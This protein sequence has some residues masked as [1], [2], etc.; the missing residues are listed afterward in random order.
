MRVTRIEPPTREPGEGWH[1][2]AELE[3]AELVAIG[4]A[5]IGAIKH[6]RDALARFSLAACTK[7]PGL[8]VKLV[9]RFF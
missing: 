6:V 8:A 7:F 1:V 5:D 3:K 9:D 4:V 2:S